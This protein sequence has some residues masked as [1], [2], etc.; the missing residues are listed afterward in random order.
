MP[1]QSRV[2]LITGA[3]SGF[4][5]E[6]T[7]L[8]LQNGDIAIA[9]YRSSSEP[10]TLSSLKSGS[11][12]D[13]ENLLLLHCD[14]TS[15]ADVKQVFATVE[16]TFGRID[17][18]FNNAGIAILGEIEG[19]P[20]DKAREMFDVNF[21]GMSRVSQEAVR[22]FRD[23]NRVRGGRLFNVSSGAGVAPSAGIGFYS[24]SKHALE[25][26][27]E[28]LMQE[29]DPAWNIKITILEPGAF[30]TRAHT[31]NTTV[32]PS[33]PSYINGPDLGSNQMRRWFEDRRGITGDPVL[34]A[35]RIYE[36]VEADDA[37]VPVRLQLGE[38]SWLRI[39]AKLEGM[40]QEQKKFEKWSKSL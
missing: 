16:Q 23:V 14:V 37:E 10:P 4:G 7:K 33:H 12:W 1:P 6:I 19:T 21:W 38:G 3:A 15:P 39:N 32:F 28:S 24:A 5:L 11:D 9:T 30:K 27:T 13:P 22:V 29:M 8:V 17:V 2:W 31:D 26:F 18:V 20:E 40:L 34:A 35:R 25:G 36:L